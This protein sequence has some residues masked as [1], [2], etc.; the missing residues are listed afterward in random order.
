MSC[1]S[2]LGSHKAS[3]GGGVQTLGLLPHPVSWESPPAFQAPNPVS[4]VR[5]AACL[6]HPAGSPRRYFVWM[7]PFKGHSKPVGRKARLGPSTLQGCSKRTELTQVRPPD[8]EGSPAY[9]PPAHHAIPLGFRISRGSSFQP[10]ET[11]GRRSATQTRAGPCRGRGTLRMFRNILLSCRC[12][13]GEGCQ[14]AQDGRAEASASGASP[15]KLRLLPLC[16]PAG[17]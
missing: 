16:S 5:A 3:W 10:A 14:R 7:D 13:V 1:Q 4:P 8:V 11:V 12:E 17:R 15:G 2:L 9:Q 6:G